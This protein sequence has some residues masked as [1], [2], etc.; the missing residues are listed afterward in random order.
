MK[1]SFLILST[2]VALFTISCK[3][4]SCVSP[5]TP[6]FTE[7]TL[8][9]VKFLNWG[10]SPSTVGPDSMVNITLMI[11]VEITAAGDSDIYIARSFGGYGPNVDVKSR[12]ASAPYNVEGTF[13]AV[14]NLVIQ[15]TGNFRIDAG[16]TAVVAYAV[17]IRTRIGNGEYQL[18]LYN[19]PCSVGQDDGVFETNVSF[20]SNYATDW[21]HA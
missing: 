9:K 17:S 7:D 16:T 6:K 20:G 19:L 12:D 5:V 18:Q 14:H 15:G 4:E 3:K 10:L 13:I 21:V 1:N 2:I 8:V 11:R